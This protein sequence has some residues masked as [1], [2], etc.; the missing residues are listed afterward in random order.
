MQTATR[1][2]VA[3]R[4][5]LSFLLNRSL[6]HGCLMPMAMLVPFTTSLPPEPSYRDMDSAA[7]FE[8][9]PKSIREE[10]ELRDIRERKPKPSETDEATDD[11]SAILGLL[12]NGAGPN[13]TEKTVANV[14]AASAKQTSE[15][16]ETGPV[17]APAGSDLLKQQT[18]SSEPLTTAA[19]ANLNAAAK[20]N[21]GS[22]EKPA[23]S[24]EIARQQ[25]LAGVSQT[26]ALNGETATAGPLKNKPLSALVPNHAA[27]DPDAATQSSLVEAAML[28]SSSAADPALAIVIDAQPVEPAMTFDT[29]LANAEPQ[30]TFE[31][32]AAKSMPAEF[33]PDK[34]QLE[35]QAESRD[36]SRAAATAEVRNESASRPLSESTRNTGISAAAVETVSFLA[37]QTG[38][39][40]TPQLSMALGSAV[41]AVNASSGS[42]LA[43]PNSGVAGGPTPA[44]P[45]EQALKTFEVSGEMQN[46]PSVRE[47][48]E[49]F[50]SEH[51][52]N[53]T[54]SD[55]SPHSSSPSY[56][57]D[58]SNQKIETSSNTGSGQSV[59]GTS[60]VGFASTS[61]TQEFSS[62]VSQEIRQPLSSQVSRA[63]LEHLEKQGSLELETLTVRLDP[64]DLGEMVIELSK[65][66]EG[67][68]VRVTAREPVTME[69]LLARGPEIETQL[70]GENLDLR[71]LEFL[72]PGMMNGGASQDHAS[73]NKS[74]PLE[75][76][77]SSGRRTARGNNSN[78]SNATPGMISHT[79]HALSFRA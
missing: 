37:T 48:L 34:M 45:I 31:S 25:R 29:G 55:Q 61:G 33:A 19:T 57:E 3:A 76:P 43:A 22:I 70:R 26:M 68:A 62:S 56:T 54:P 67:L 74:A 38:A 18:S 44:S 20:E 79:N 42:S 17:G 50:W 78:A 12:L 5:V 10:S 2:F 59:A 28:Q 11:F 7:K 75:D 71:S 51:S 64:A 36:S 73:Q 32:T 53:E 58:L 66:K 49:Q 60:A 30:T 40:A 46:A 1:E 63:V 16:A 4:D 13:P 14:D 39:G 21:S 6:L 69:M 23:T 47:S 35:R 24:E 52:E 15:S 27:V 41:S 72:A 8:P 9:K 65:T 77:Q